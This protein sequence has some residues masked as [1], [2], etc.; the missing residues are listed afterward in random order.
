MPPP[1]IPPIHCLLSFEALARLRSVTLAAE[2]L[3][4]T[5]SA[6]SH[7]MRQ[8][9]SQLGV[10]LFAR[11][12]FALTADGAAYLAHVRQGLQALQQ[13][14]GSATRTG[15]PTRLRLAVTPTFSREIL[16]PKLAL[17]RHAYP[18]VELIM[19]VAIPLS[20]VKAEEADL[21]VRY[22]TGPYADVEQVCVL[23][24]EV[25]PVCSPDYFNEAGPFNG[26]DTAEV[27]SRARLIR[28]PLEPWGTWFRACGINLAEPRSGGTQFNDVG[29]L[30][31]AAAAGFGVALARLRLAQ[32]WLDTGRLLRLSAR[33]V[34]SPQHHFLCWKPG[35][36]E[37]WEC[38]AFVEW[39]KSTLARQS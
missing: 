26:F 27:V 3:S 6:V 30:L 28:S 35:T 23:R 36:L 31:D 22:G 18:E 19:Q 16:L 1:R 14:P 10:R 29:L 37:R 20:N 8:L 17:F 38:A 5:P 33:V 32:S 4:V 2:E 13:L 24:D 34:P 12:D 39:L 11:G 7:R 25:C 9:E 21:E 15:A